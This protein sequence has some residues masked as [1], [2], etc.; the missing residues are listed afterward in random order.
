MI[1]SIACSLL[2]VFAVNA[3]AADDVQ[4]APPEPADMK[5]IFNG[6]DLT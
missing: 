3:F 4:T 6:K 1:R 5:A 2:T